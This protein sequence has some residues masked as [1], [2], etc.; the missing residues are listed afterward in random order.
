MA[1]TGKTRWT[2]AELIDFE[3]ALSVWDGEVEEKAVDR[4]RSAAM[5][6]WLEE[7]GGAGVGHHWLAVLGGIGFMLMVLMS[8][9]GAG[10]VWGVLDRGSNG[11]NVVWLLGVTLVA[12]WLLMLLAIVLWLMRGRIP[13]GGLVAWVA[14]K[15]SLRFL[16][17][18]ARAA[19]DRVRRS[20]ELARVLG[21][22]TAS[23]TQLVAA[24]FHAGAFAGL[25]WMVLVKR[26]GF[27][28]ETTTEGAMRRMLEGAVEVLSAPWRWAFPELV[29]DVVESELFANWLKHGTSWWPFLLM[30]LLVWGVFPRMVLSV[31]ARANERRALSK[32]TFQAPAHRKLWRAL[33]AVKRGEDPVG[34]VDGALVVSLGGEPDHEVLRPFLLQQLRMNPTGWES[35]GVMDEGREEA[36]RSALAKAPAGIVLV[37]EAWSLAPRQL[38]RALEEVGK[39]A[40]GRRVALVVTGVA[41]DA[42]RAEWER[43]IDQRQAGETVELWFCETA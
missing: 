10:A 2:L 28:W 43:F 1:G 36:A 32:L 42:Q 4:E 7:R 3:T 15:G 31:W 26:V 17:E 9:S 5:K 22:R 21:W 35:M 29:P 13:G 8:A 30:T 38:E 39:V 11:V 33:T 19:I 18:D 23:L 25:A 40:E 24:S 41:G 20:G 37:A 27:F 34:P 14:E 12:P 16:S 6:T